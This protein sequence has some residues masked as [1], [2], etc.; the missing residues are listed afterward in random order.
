MKSDIS[1][2]SIRIDETWHIDPYKQNKINQTL[3][4]NP[5]KQNKTSEKKRKERK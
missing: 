3:N 2:L 1:I 5:D 4:T